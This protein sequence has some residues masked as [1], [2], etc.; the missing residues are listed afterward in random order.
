LFLQLLRLE[1]IVGVEER[2]KITGR[3]RKAAVARAGEAFVFLPHEFDARIGRCP[4]KRAGH[5]V[6]RTVVHHDDF[7]GNATK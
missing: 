2:E 5:I 1:G 6:G 4:R 3:R 7:V